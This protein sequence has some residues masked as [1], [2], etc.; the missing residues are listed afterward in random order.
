MCQQAKDPP[1][2]TSG[3]EYLTQFQSI[4]ITEHQTNRLFFIFLFFNMINEC[5][6]S[7]KSIFEENDKLKIFFEEQNQPWMRPKQLN[8]LSFLYFLRNQPWT[9]RSV[10]S[11]RR[12]SFF[13]FF[14]CPPECFNSLCNF[15]LLP[16]LKSER[17]RLKK[18]RRKKRPATYDSGALY[19]SVIT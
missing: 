10:A 5:Q 1:A 6:L 12:L 16:T 8:P 17:R 19:R 15:L 11:C 4:F 14:F 9:P 7:K 2:S 3:S 18:R 13:S